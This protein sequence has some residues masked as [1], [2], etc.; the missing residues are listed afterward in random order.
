MINVLLIIQLFICIAMIGLILIQR[1]E[2]G[3]LGIGGGGG[4]GGGLMSG[5]SAANV[6]TRSTTVMGILFFLNSVALAGLFGVEAQEKAIEDAAKE[7]QA[8]V[9]D[10][11]SLE[12]DLPSDVTIDDTVN[13]PVSDDST[14]DPEANE[15]TDPEGE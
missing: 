7:E 12:E 14:A 6:V 9:Q 8:I 15:E 1:S 11:E 13:E 3:G 4:G 2:G 10:D 5:R